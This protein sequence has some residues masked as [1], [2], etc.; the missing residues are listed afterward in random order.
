MIDRMVSLKKMKI[1]DFELQEKLLQ[2]EDDNNSE[3]ENPILMEIMKIFQKIKNNLQKIEKN[4][5][6]LDKLSDSLVNSVNEE[7]EKMI[8]LSIKKII[9]NNINFSKENEN[10]LKCIKKICETKTKNLDNSEKNIIK[11]NFEVLITKNKKILELNL[12]KQKKSK[13]KIKSKLKRQLQALTDLDENKIDEILE[14]SQ[15]T[16]KLIKKKIIGSANF[17]IINNL[18]DIQ[19]KYNDIIL[20]EKNIKEINYIINQISNLTNE[21]NQEIKFIDQNFDSLK[22]NVFKANIKLK[23]AVMN[24]KESFKKRCCLLIIIL[25]SVCVILGP[26]F[27]SILFSKGFL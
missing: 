1:N 16:Q 3:I 15:K 19:N 8:S 21:Q 26:I 12:K 6:L 10:L 4:L 11:Q 14:D 5:S 13:N 17:Q 2:E 9:Q 20:L 27:I 22:K 25:L 7:T 24:E 18:N 23:N